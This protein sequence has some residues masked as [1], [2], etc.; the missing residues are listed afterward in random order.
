ME[1]IMALDEKDDK[2]YCS[3]K[4]CQGLFSAYVEA[5]LLLPIKHSLMELQAMFFVIIFE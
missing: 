5:C 3:M 1:D 2:F 4:C